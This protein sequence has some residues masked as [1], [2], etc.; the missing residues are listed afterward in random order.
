M[1]SAGSGQITFIS[2]VTSQT[3]VEQTAT[4]GAVTAAFGQETLVVYTPFLAV[5]MSPN[6]T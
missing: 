3:V 1:I 5:F 4:T 6:R 2:V